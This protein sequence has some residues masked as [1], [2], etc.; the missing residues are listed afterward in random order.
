MNRIRLEGERVTLRPLSMD[1]FEREWANRLEIDPSVQPIMPTRD[2]LRVRFERSGIM[3]S[4]ALD[5]AIEVDGRKVGGIQTYL[6]PD[7]TLPSGAFEIGIVI[8]EPSM[9]GKGTGTEAV[10]LLVRWLFSHAGAT[11]IHMPTVP[12]NVAMRTVAERL[13]FEADGMIRYEGQ[14]FVFLVLTRERWVAGGSV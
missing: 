11:R 4:G 2:A 14:E 9:R 3:D 8:D 12:D 5:L 1:E 6:P 13:G 7:R 10:R